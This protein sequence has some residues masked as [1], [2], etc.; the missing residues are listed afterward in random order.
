MNETELGSNYLIYQFPDI[1]KEWDIEKNGEKQL[2]TIKCGSNYKAYWKCKK[3]HRWEAVIKDRTQGNGCPYCSGR[4]A[5]PGETDLVTLRPDIA[6]QWHPA[7]NEEKTPDQFAV[8]SGK[9]A[10]WICERG[11]EWRAVIASRTQ[12][13]GCPYCSGRKVILG[14]TDLVT[15][16]PDI[17]LEWHPTLNGKKTPDQFAVCSGKKAWWICERGHEWETVIGKRTQGSGCPYCSRQK[18]IPGETDLMT[19]EPDIAL[20][21]HPTLNGKKTPDQFTVGSRKKAWWICERGHEWEAMIMNRTRGNGCPYCSGNKVIP[22]ETDLATL[23]PDI[24]LEW[25]PA[26]NGEKTPDQFGVYSNKKAWWICERGHEWET[27]IG[28]RTQGSGCQ[29]CSRRKAILGETD[30]MTLE[31]DIALEWHPTLN[32]KK[33]PNQ[34]TVGSGKK[35]WWICEQGHEW[36]AMIGNRTRGNGCPYCSRRKAILGETDLVTL[37]PD[38]ASEWHPALNGEKT[39]DQFG[40]CSNKKA[41]WICEQGHEWEAMIINRTRGNG[42][43][44]C[45]RRKAILGETD[46]VTLRP[47]IAS[48]WHP[49]LN[50]EKTPDQFGVCSNKK[51]WWICERGH[52]WRTSVENRTQGKGCPYC[53]GRKVI[54]GETDLMTLEPDIALE[55][56]PT[57]NGKKTPNQ[58]TVGSGKKAWWICEQGHEWRTSILSRTRGNGCPVCYRIGLVQESRR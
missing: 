18:A 49:A 12:G 1:A 43:P 45:S 24:A 9:K 42:C 11:H 32:G 52:E 4:K 39:P 35:A 14:E 8:Y 21:W 54:P 51:A 55:W 41:W 5:I 38:I 2:D 46:L 19:L 16:R 17:A 58:F 47:D 3:N 30:L 7:L 53:S 15:L 37:R 56:H 29:Y 13:S 40:V 36:E 57:L 27:V 48:E 34:F 44:Y 31:P 22:G 50:G 23:R 28:K 25:H 10:W 26:L 20:E 6:S 33:T